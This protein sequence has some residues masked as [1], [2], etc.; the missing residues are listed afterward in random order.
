MCRHINK[1][2]VCTVCFL[3]SCIF[4]FHSLFCV[5]L[6]RKMEREC[7]LKKVS[8]IIWMHQEIRSAVSDFCGTKNSSFGETKATV[9]ETVA[10][11]NSGLLCN[12]HV[13]NPN[14]WVVWIQGWLYVYWCFCKFVL[15]CM[16]HFV[17]F[18]KSEH[19]LHFWV[20]LYCF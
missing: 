14:L 20:W 11:R 3:H 10:L 7:Y 6:S 13:Y 5:V 16:Y 1:N 4:D 18:N 19:I 17:F 15:L 9:G 2:A 8:K 12:N